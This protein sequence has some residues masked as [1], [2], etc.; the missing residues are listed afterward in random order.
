MW[1]GFEGNITWQEVLEIVE[2][3]EPQAFCKTI[4][5]LLLRLVCFNHK[6]E[7]R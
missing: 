2:I 6:S 4:D 3:L 5:G 7:V 1:E